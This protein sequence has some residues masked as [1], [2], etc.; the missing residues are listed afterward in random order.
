MEARICKSYSV[1][2]APLRDY[3]Y[4]L[5]AQSCVPPARSLV[6]RLTNLGTKQTWR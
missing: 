2:N 5:L 1:C 4:R 3:V 6:R